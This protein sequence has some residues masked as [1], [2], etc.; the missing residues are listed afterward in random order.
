MSSIEKKARLEFAEQLKKY[1]DTACISQ[2][3]LAQGLGMQQPYIAKIEKANHSIGLDM[4]VIISTYFGV[5]YYQLADPGFPIPMREKLHE[6]IRKFHKLKST[7]TGYLKDASPNYSKNI[8]KYLKGG[9]LNE[10]KTSKEIAV[11]FLHLYQ[12]TIPPSK[13]SDILCRPPR[14][15]LLDITKPENGRGNRYKLKKKVI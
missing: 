9:Y 3:H 4:L 10:E 13:V 8:D 14:R 5:K 2:A 7:D 15:D 6:S 12:Q 11:D 1:R